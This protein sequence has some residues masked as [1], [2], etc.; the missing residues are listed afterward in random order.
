MTTLQPQPQRT[1]LP[2]TSITILNRQRLDLGDIR[3]M[4]DSIQQHGLI[5]PIVI[6]QNN[7]L[8]AGE[9]RYR[10]HELLGRTTI[11]VVYKEV[12]SEDILHE[13][14][15]EENIRRKQM[16]WQERCLNIATIHA[17][18][19]K[20]AAIDGASWGQRETGELIGLAATRVNY[21][22]KMADLLR[23]E[24]DADSKPLPTARFWKCD[25]FSD[26]WKLL[27]RDEEEKLLSELAA[28]HARSASPTS[29]SNQ[30]LIGVGCIDDPLGDGYKAE[31]VESNPS[32]I[33]NCQQNSNEESIDITQ[34]PPSDQE[35]ILSLREKSCLIG[36]E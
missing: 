4:A 28:R 8:I 7:R 24:L 3:D 33:S 36:W 32:A 17:L 5:Q 35:L 26:A 34:L 29:P 2:L 22:L 25:N 18:K 12:L 1:T 13:L 20:R 23:A 30:S 21:S 16:T 6:D 10:A 27:M 31:S 19:R 9:R 14:E 11:D 15:L